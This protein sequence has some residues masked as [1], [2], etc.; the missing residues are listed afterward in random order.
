MADQ[1]TNQTGSAS[2]MFSAVSGWYAQRKREWSASGVARQA[3]GDQLE[4]KVGNIAPTD[5]KES[6]LEAEKSKAEEEAFVNVD[7]HDV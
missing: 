1:L 5:K 4:S 6:D 7:I 3:D 2:Q